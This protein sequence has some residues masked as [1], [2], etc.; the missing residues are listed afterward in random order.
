MNP[1]VLCTIIAAPDSSSGKKTVDGRADCGAAR[2]LRFAKSGPDYIG[3]PTHALAVGRDC[4]NFDSGLPDASNLPLLSD[5]TRIG[6]AIR[7]GR[8]TDARREDSASPIYETIRRRDS[9]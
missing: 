9:N 8:S 5:P 3:Q 7:S 4:R 2:G 6:G 1:A